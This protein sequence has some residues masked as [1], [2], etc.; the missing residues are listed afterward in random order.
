MDTKKLESI[1]ATI[2]KLITL[3]NDKGATQGESETAM[4]RATALMA[5][6][7]LD[8]A[9][10]LSQKIKKGENLDVIQEEAECYYFESS[11]NWEYSLGWSIGH[12]FDC[13]TIQSRNGF[14]VVNDKYFPSFK[15]IFIGLPD[16]VALALY[17]FDYC[18]NEIGRET[19]LFTQQKRKG[20]DFALGMSARIIERLTE[21]YKKVA[22]QTH[23][24]CTALI[25]VKKDAIDKYVKEEFPSLRKGKPI[26][27]KDYTAYMQGVAAGERVTLSSNRRQVK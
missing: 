15:M 24:T 8:Q 2:A 27:I 7:Q 12:I 6:Y 21:M 9:E 18:Q 1:K 3:A 19:E 11:Y 10:V 20:N 13:K 22:E 23:E 25:V 5:K 16:D 4:E 17:F 14:A 26:K